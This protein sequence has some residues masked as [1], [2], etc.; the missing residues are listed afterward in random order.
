M[1]RKKQQIRSYE[2][3]QDPKFHIYMD[4]LIVTLILDRMQEEGGYMLSLSVERMPP[5]E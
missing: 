4:E 2:E 5:T 3:G 1:R